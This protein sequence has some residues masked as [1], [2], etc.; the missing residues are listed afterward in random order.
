MPAAGDTRENP[1]TGER[2]TF[3]KTAGATN[4][5]GSGDAMLRALPITSWMTQS[6]T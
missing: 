4:G 5:A 1:H 2:T 3:L 6:S